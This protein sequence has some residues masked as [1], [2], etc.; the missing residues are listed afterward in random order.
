MLGG[1]TDKVSCGVTNLFIVIAAYAKLHQAKHYSSVLV[2]VFVD[3]FYCASLSQNNVDETQN[4][5]S[6]YYLNL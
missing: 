2:Y 3:L 6:K 1:L 4:T 5:V